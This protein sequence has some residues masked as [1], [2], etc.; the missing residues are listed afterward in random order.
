M[1]KISTKSFLFNFTCILCFGVIGNLCAYAQKTDSV[2]YISRARKISKGPSIKVN[3]PTYRPI[4]NGFGSIPYNS[5]LLGKPTASKPEKNLTFLK[6]FP[7]PVDDQISV[8]FKL[9]RE[10]QVS[11]KIMDLLGNEVVTLANE[12][13][14]SGEQTKT[15]TIASRLTSGI[16]FVRIVAG[17]ETSVKRISVL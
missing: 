1:G 6:V 7:N 12:R 3:T 9:E 4:V 10:S 8:V 15:Y 14:S 17:A 5:S 13:A 11:I 2:N 16:Y